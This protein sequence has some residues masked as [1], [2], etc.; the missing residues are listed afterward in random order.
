MSDSEDSALDALLMPGTAASTK[1][2]SVTMAMSGTQKPMSVEKSMSPQAM[3]PHTE[4]LPTESP[5]PKAPATGNP[6][7][8]TLTQSLASLVLRLFGSQPTFTP[9]LALRLPATGSLPTFTPNLALRLPA[10][11][12][13]LTFTLSLAASPPR[14]A[15]ENPLT[16]TLSQVC[17]ALQVPKLF[18]L[19]L[20]PRL[21]FI[22]NPSILLMRLHTALMKLDTAVPTKG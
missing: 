1:P 16:F 10:T 4:S 17:L 19:N 6:P 14:L 22:M 18:I 5:A 11:E 20:A 12:N 21:T 13:P 2:A 3:K 9:N 8:F 7:T 15:T